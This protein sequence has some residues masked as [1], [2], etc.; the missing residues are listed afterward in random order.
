MLQP[1]EQVALTGAD[2]ASQTGQDHSVEFKALG[3]VDRHE[4]QIRPGLWVGS[5]EQPFEF[6]FKL[7]DNHVRTGVFQQVQH[8]ADV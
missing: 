3:F 2:A 6:P 1:P 8:L 4:L 7:F 5:G